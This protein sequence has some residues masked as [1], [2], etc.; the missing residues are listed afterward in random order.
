M[1]QPA[2]I[3]TVP[4][5]GATGVSPSATVVFTFST[6]MDTTATTALFYDVTAG[7]QQP[8]VIPVWSAGD[9]VL[10]CTPSPAFVNNHNIEWIV[11]GQDTL[12]N[13]LNGGTPVFGSFTTGSGGGGGGNLNTNVLTGFVV[14]KAWEYDQTSTA[15]PLLDTNLPYVFSGVTSLASNRTATTIT[16]TL[17]TTAVSNLLQNIIYP[18]DYY[19]GAYNTNLSAYNAT[20][21]AG[22]YVFNVYSNASDQQV[23]VKLPAYAQ[24]NAPQVSNYAAAQSINPS[25]PFTLTWDAFTGGGSTDY[26]SVVIGTLFQ[27]PGFGLTNSLHGTATSVTIP[28]NTLSASSNYDASLAF[29]HAVITT[30]GNYVTEAFV[31]SYTSF[32]ITTA[33]SSAAAPVLTNAS[34]WGGEFW[35]QH[36]DF[37]GPDGDG[38]LQH[39]LEQR[40]FKLAN[41][42]DHQQSRQQSPHQ[43]PALRD[44]QN[45][46]L[47]RTQRHLKGRMVT[48]FPVHL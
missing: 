44:E 46:V 42:A 20:F 35:L 36:P 48:Q 17:P 4:S 38:D 27:T 47:P 8:T 30:N 22:N 34:N 39:Q 45:L 23:T 29:Y 41:L 19:V 12:A 1:A 21:T 31:A 37:T 24:P 26:V 3:S 6:A 9:T 15:T 11:S 2:I 32:T 5:N 7:Y 13:P 14:G 28:A 33:G 18:W 40:L 10:T 43:R 16:L 25:L